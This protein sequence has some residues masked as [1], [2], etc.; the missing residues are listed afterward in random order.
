VLSVPVQVIAWNDL[1]PK[2]PIM[3]QAGCKT[4]LAHS[5]THSLTLY[6]ASQNEYRRRNSANKVRMLNTTAYD[7]KWWLV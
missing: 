6:G 5:L 4:L 3:C 2:W 7:Q 1:S